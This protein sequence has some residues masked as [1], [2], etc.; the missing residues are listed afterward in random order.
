MRTLAIGDIHGCNTALVTLLNEVKPAQEDQLVFLGDYIDG[1]PAS[2][3]V[4]SGILKN[5]PSSR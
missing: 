2:R 1:G 3:Q 5:L 4:S